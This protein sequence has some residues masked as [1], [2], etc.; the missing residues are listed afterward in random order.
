[1][2]KAP[3]EQEA[4]EESRQRLQEIA[5]IQFGGLSDDEILHFLAERKRLS[6]LERE[7]EKAQEEEAER[8]KREKSAAALKVSEKKKAA[9]LKKIEVLN[10][11]ITP[12]KQDDDLLVLVAERRALE[13]ELAAAGGE[14]VSETGEAM[15][16]PRAPAP[17]AV[18]EEALP[19]KA[20]VPPRETVPEIAPEEPKETEG[21]G[22]QETGGE[23][24]VETPPQGFQQAVRF[25]NEKISDHGIEGGT[26]FDRYF[27]QL[28]SNVGSLGELLQALPLNAKKNKAFM[29]KVAEIDPAYAMHYADKETLKR[30]EDFNVRIAALN[31]PRN[32]GNA[33]SEM[34][35]EAR[36][37]KVL[38]VAVKQDY[39]NVRFI[40]PDM[41]DYDEMLDIAKKTT[42]EKVKSLKE[43][44]DITVLVPRLLQQDK[45][46]MLQ[47]KAMTDP[48]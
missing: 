35:P 20:L 8:F 12:E 11:S 27:N 32:S 5:G 47:V 39:R 16:E 24:A 31:N 10:Q 38:L 40:Q 44:A 21:D 28:Q 15:P 2:A 43:A 9:I 4:L 7:Y 25:G 3:K 23:T 13:K 37:S 33:L 18:A 1:M 42:L 30:D 19:A 36:T 6:D 48:Q 46:F 26:E 17:V 34:L 29:L 14:T 41:A 22:G 45:P